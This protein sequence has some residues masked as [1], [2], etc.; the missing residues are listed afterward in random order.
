MNETRERLLD[1]AER[2]Y[3]ER[4]I[5]A[6]SL[7]EIVQ[8]AGARNA[9]AV[10]YHFGDRAGIVRAIFARHAPE[11]E[12][13]RHALLDA[14]EA[15]GG[16]GG[17]ALAAALVR[18]M[19]ARLGDASGRAFLQIW[20][21]VVNRPRPLLPLAVPDDPPEPGAGGGAA[22]PPKTDSLCRWRDLVEPVLEEDAA[23]LHRR[24]T[25]IL[26]AATELAR[27]ARSGPR[28]DD[29]LF[30]SYLIDVVAAILGAP[31]SE[32]TRRLADER[33]AARR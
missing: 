16:T 14:Y 8:A 10:Q 27:R 15:D 5:D 29:R 18:P 32:E 31:V 4:G 30:T 3:A 11:I 19:A 9:T 28:T 26:Y 33:D 12:A 7:R 13:R 6:V 2:L 25:A 1:A 23:R 17:R 24:F 20:A 22:Q 21:D